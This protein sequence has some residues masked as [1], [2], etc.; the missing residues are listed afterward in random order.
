MAAPALLDDP[1]AWADRPPIAGPQ[2]IYGE[3]LPHRHEMALLD[4]ILAVDL[5]ERFAVAYHDARHDHFWVRG[6]VPGRP[7][8]PG[9]LIVEVAAQLCS[10]VTTFLLDPSRDQFFGFAG[11]DAV[12]FRGQIRPGDRLV[13][14]AKLARLRRTFATYDTQGWVDGA[15]VFEGVI[16]GAMI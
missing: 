12:R 14:A 1:K 5:D 2:D 4:G 3:R 13:V 9:V 16:L 15:P 11:V 6:H 8:M 7:I 10:W